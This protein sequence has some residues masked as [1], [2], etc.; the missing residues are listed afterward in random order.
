MSN[1]Y[2]VGGTGNWSD[3]DN[4]WAATSGGSPADGN[5][6]T[7]SDDIFIDENSGFGSGG[8]IT[9]DGDSAE[10]YNFTS[11]S[12]HNYT[13][14]YSNTDIGIYG[15]AIF[16]VGTTFDSDSGAYTQFF[17]IDTHTITINGASIF[18]FRVSGSG[19][20]TLQDNL[21]VI[22]TFKIEKGIFDA[23]DKN[24]TANKFSFYISSGSIINV[25]MGSGIWEA[26]GSGNVWSIEQYDGDSVTITPET[27]TIKFTDASEFN[28]TFYFYDDTA[29]EIGKTYNNLW[30][31]GSGTGKFIIHGSNTFNKI[32]CDN[33]PHSIKFQDGKTTTINTFTVSGT[34]GNLITIDSIDAITQHILSKSSGIVECDY[35]DISNSNATGGAT[36]YAGSHSVDTTNND[37]WIFEDKPTPL[38]PKVI[39]KNK[40]NLLSIGS[41]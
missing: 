40:L 6:P 13:I 34:S 25:I 19:T 9:L 38:S 30:L 10:C 21:V 8:T 14:V 26:T 5:L 3:D 31:G 29:N 12:G 37:G 22:D 39:V 17:G 35:L 4:H 15:S 36:W 23:N 11:T 20:F 33:P 41:L 16:E 1:R 18:Y 24:I 2:W 7:S 32:T 28:K 27:S